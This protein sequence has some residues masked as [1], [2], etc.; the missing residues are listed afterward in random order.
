MLVS[1]T[2]QVSTLKLLRV[3]R[4]SLHIRK[5]GARARRMVMALATKP[6]DLNWIPRAYLVAGKNQLWKVVP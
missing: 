3:L 1:V 5:T 2:E 6:V 4:M